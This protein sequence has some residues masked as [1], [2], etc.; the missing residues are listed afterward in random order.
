MGVMVSSQHAVMPFPSSVIPL[1]FHLQSESLNSWNVEGQAPTHTH[2]VKYL[3][4]WHTSCLQLIRTFFFY[5]TRHWG[6]A[7]FRWWKI[8]AM[9]VS[10]H[11]HTQHTAPHEIK[12][13]TL[14]S[15]DFCYDR[16]LK[17][18]IMR[19]RLS[20]IQWEVKMTREIACAYSGTSGHSRGHLRLRIE[21]CYF[22]TLKKR[23][24]NW[25]RFC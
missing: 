5:E 6:S 23:N 18:L 17:D 7:N 24:R 25:F 16:N 9:N 22:N 10:T 1:F 20:L 3:H 11:L 2:T 21:G 4:V 19:I 15:K 14:C 12:L 8:K 13:F